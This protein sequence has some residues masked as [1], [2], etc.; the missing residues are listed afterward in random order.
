MIQ[1][2]GINPR[3][4]AIPI[5]SKK[6]LRNLPQ[7]IHLL[8]CIAAAKYKVAEAT[9]RRWVNMKTNSVKCRVCNINFAYEAELVRHNRNKKHPLDKDRIQQKTEVEQHTR[10]ENIQT[11]IQ[12]LRKLLEEKMLSDEQYES[13]SENQ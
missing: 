12:A 1:Q 6:K 3:T 5:I 13:E 8:L 9:V 10:V 7:K 11:N 4:E 2:K